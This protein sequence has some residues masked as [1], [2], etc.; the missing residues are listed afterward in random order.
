[1]Q[2]TLSHC[3]KSTPLDDCLST[4]D[5]HG[6][7]FFSTELEEQQDQS[8]KKDEGEN[9]S[10]HVLD[11]STLKISEIQNQISSP[12]EKLRSVLKKV[13]DLQQEVPKKQTKLKK[14][15]K[16]LKEKEKALEQK[17]PPRPLTPSPILLRLD[18]LP[19][20]PILLCE[21]LITPPIPLRPRLLRPAPRK[22]EVGKTTER[23]KA[24]NNDSFSNLY[25][26]GNPGSGKS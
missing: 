23:L 24:L 18:S 22:S 11:L 9:N 7:N 17:R 2:K 16:E 3:S 20:S 6:E 8:A 5:N 25:I 13:N 14:K 26:S 1:M 10:F 4:D 21:P 19:P 12:T 15:V